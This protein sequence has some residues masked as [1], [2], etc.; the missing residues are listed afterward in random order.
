MRIAISYEDGKVFQHF[1]RTESF[2]LYDVEDDEIIS[3]EIFNADGAGHEAL[4]ALLAEHDIDVLICGGLGGGAMAALQASGIEVISGVEGEVD[5]V[6][7]RY[8]NGE[9]EST[10]VNCDHHEEESGDCDCGGGCGSCGGGCGG[11]GGGCGGGEP[12]ILIEGPNAGKAVKV[13]YTG[14]LNDGTKFD[15][16]YDRGETL[17]FVCGIGMMIRGFDEAVAQMSVGETVKIHLTPDQ[18]YGEADPNMFVKAKIAEMKG[19]EELV[20]GDEVYL[21]DQM[22]RPHRAR[23]IEKTETDIQFD[24]NHEMAGKELNFE[25]TLVAIDE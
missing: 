7:K 23:V 15:S 10:G 12:Q 20:V 8:I 25:I 22:G 24:A 14:T 13:H 21:Y 16:S 18:A 6:V 9:I 5:E 17:D 19:S 1:G 2:K 3:S 4:A 11:C